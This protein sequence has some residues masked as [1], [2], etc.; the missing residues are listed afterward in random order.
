MSLPL[1]VESRG[2]GGIPVVFVHSFAGDISHWSAQLEHLRPRRR[3]VAFDLSGHG[4]S[5]AAI[6]RYSIEELA[7]D[8]G[9]VADSLALER[10]VLVGHSMGALIATEYTRTHPGRVSM[11]GLVDAPPAPAALAPEEQQQIRAALAHA[12]LA[13]VE[14]F[15]TQRAFVGA[16]LPVREKMLEALRRLP[17]AMVAELATD[18]LTYDATVGL[19]SYRGSKF[20]IV[21]PANDTPLSLHNAVPGFQH[22]VIKNTGHWIQLD[23]PARFNAV[24]D[25]FLAAL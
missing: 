20:A 18:S 8:V 7:K 12:P 5:P 21:T 11:L 3:A 19:R 2:A 24:L 14:Q 10:F 1:N 13:T 9:F 17:G 16:R 6:G 4:A 25:V 15:W 23:D 22:T